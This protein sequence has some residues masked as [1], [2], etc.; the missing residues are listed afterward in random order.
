MR[1]AVALVVIAVTGVGVCAHSQSLP[2]L[3]PCPPGASESAC[4][5]SHHDLKEAKTAFAH[6]VKLQKS[7]PEQAYHE[8]DRAAQLV[9]RNVQYLTARESAR[10]QL[11]YTH[12]ERG[13]RE[14]ETGNQVEALADFRNALNLDPA[15]TFAQERL[16][17]SLGDSLPKTTA[18]PS[19]VEE[20]PVIR[21]APNLNRA[22]FHFRGDSKDLLTTIAT[23]YGVSAQLEDSVTSRRVNFNIDDV[24]FYQAMSAAGQVTQ[25]FW[26]PLSEKQMLVAADKP[27]NRRQYERLA[28]RTFYIPGATSTPTALNDVM[29]LLRNLFELRFI[30]P[31]AGSS[32]LVVRGPQ[33]VLDAA[34]QFLQAMDSSRPQVMIDVHVYQVNHTLTRNIGVHIPNQFTLFNI[35]AG[36]LAALGGQNIQDLINQLISSGGINQ[37]NNTA[38]SA[39]LAQL[40]SQQSQQNSIFSQPLATFGGGKTLMGLS[41]DQLSAELSMNE[42]SIKTLDHASLRASQGTDT[43]FRIGSRIPILNATFAPVFN[44]AAIS[45]VLQNN[46]FQAAFPSFSYEDLGLTVKAKPSITSV[47]NVGLQLEITIRSLAGMS[48]NGVPVLGNREYKASITLVDGEPAVVAGQVTHSE[49]LALTGIPGLGQF[50]GL[51]KI[52]AS[53]SKQYE[54]DELLVVI[55]PHIISRSMGQNSEVYLSK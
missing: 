8:L 42:G 40:Q 13:N 12:I 21:L 28:M 48:F 39:L 47:S 49:I 53:N 22:S 4:N 23:A 20:S 11:V 3:L 37:A 55:T 25:V 52:T 26:T 31:N 41:L 7:D 33:N 35:P 51:N 30:T 5:P 6:G 29:N 43:T 16:R 19:V 27:E 36:A 46:S 15:N 50:P 45:S 1:W 32:T 18:P 38:I 17:D 44:T 2:S 54:D 9:P 10:Q 34:T 24:D 14:L